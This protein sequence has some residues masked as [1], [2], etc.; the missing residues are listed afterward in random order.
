[1]DTFP[2]IA[3][4]LRAIANDPGIDWREK[5]KRAAERTKFVGDGSLPIIM[6]ADLG[7]AIIEGAEPAS[8]PAEVERIILKAAG[9]IDDMNSRVK[10]LLS[11]AKQFD[12]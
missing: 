6:I 2:A 1:M 10:S 4:D 3:A 5:L 7:G 8:Y 11:G 9:A 12:A